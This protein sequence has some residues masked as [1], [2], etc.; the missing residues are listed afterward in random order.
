MRIP[1]NVREQALKA[2]M[3]KQH[4]QALTGAKSFEKCLDL[5]LDVMNE[6]PEAERFV[7]ERKTKAHLLRV[8]KALREKNGG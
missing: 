5:L 3:K 4:K 1:I 7:L 8:K 6:I 2:E